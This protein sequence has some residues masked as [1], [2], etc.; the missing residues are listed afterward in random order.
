MRQRRFAAAVGWASLLVWGVV[1]CGLNTCA[2]AQIRPQGPAA[3]Q[4]PRPVQQPAPPGQPVPQ[5]PVP[6]A[7]APAPRPPAPPSTSQRL[8]APVEV[9]GTDLLTK[10]GVQL[11]A[12]YYPSNKGKDAAVVMLIHGW[13][14]SRRDFDRLAPFLQQQGYAVFVPDLRGHGGSTQR[15]LPTPTTITVDKMPPVEVA[16][17]VDMDLE[18]CKR[19]LLQKNNA[20]ELNIEKLCLLGLDVG[21]TVALDWARLDW[22][23]PVYPGLKQGQDVKALILISPKW[24][25]P[26]LNVQ[27]AMSHPAVTKALSIFLIVGKDSSKDLADAQRMYNIFSRFHPMPKDENPELRDL[28]FA[29]LPSSAQGKD[30]LLRFEQPLF[31]SIAYFIEH[32]V[33]K[34]PFPWQDRSRR[35]ED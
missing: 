32:R 16:R 22:S 23:W 19:F 1:T 29:K 12:T 20:G 6:P 7:A 25:V 13:K 5:R 15:L 28:Y 33:A 4:P 21:A 8:P 31:Q 18:T 3:N 10:D 30:L 2:T 17:M 14:G 9:S 35:K 24:S 26:G 11:Q 34:Q 27:A